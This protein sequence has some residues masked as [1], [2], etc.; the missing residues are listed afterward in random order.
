MISIDHFR[1]REERTLFLGEVITKLK[2]SDE[3]KEIYHL[4]LE[5]LDDAGFQSFYEKITSQLNSVDTHHIR[6]IEPLT[7]QLLH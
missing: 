4:C 1:T 2:I 5:V 7:W 3:E 6:S